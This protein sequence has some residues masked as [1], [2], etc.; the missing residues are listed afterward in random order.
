MKPAKRYLNDEFLDF[1]G[2]ES[3]CKHSDVFSKFFLTFGV[4]H[5]ADK[6][7]MHWFLDTILSY[8]EIRQVSA[9]NFQIWTL[10]RII[11]GEKAGQWR[12]VLYNDSLPVIK[13][14]FSTISLVNGYEEKFDVF[15]IYLTNNILFLPSEN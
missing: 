9:I 4:K 2:S 12:V 15:K 10:E 5:I 3:Y 1:R 11:M 14:I 7:G 6:C 8:Q 13:Q